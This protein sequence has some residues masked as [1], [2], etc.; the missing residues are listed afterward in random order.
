LLVEC[1]VDAGKKNDA[2]DFS[3]VTSDF[4]EQHTP[5]LYPRIFSIQVH[6]DLIDVSN[7]LTKASPKLLAIYKLQ[8]LKNTAVNEG[9]KESDELREIFLLLTHSSQTQSSA[10]NSFSPDTNH[11]H[12]VI[13]TFYGRIELLLEL[14]FLSLQ[15]KAQFMAEECV[16]ELKTIDDIAVWQRIMVECVE[17]K[18]ALSKQNGNIE[19][20]TKSSVEAQLSVVSRLE[21]LL[22]RA[23]REGDAEV[24]QS[25][26][27]A[28]WNSCL[29]L[30]QHNLR[31]NLKSPL[32]TLSQALENMNSML[33][34]MRCQIHAELAAIEEEAERLEPAA[35]HLQ[36]ALVLD[37]SGQFQQR[38]SFHLHLIQLRSNLY[39][40][41]TSPEDQAAMLIQQTKERLGNETAKKWRHTLVSAG[42]ALAPETFQMVLDA[43][44]TAKVSGSRLQDNVEQLAAKAKHYRTCAQKVE[45]HLARMERDTNYR[46]RYRMRLWVSLVKAARKEELWDICRAACRFCLLYDD[47]RWTVKCKQTYKEECGEREL[48]RLLAE[49]HFINAE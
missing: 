27:V 12:T 25:V 46:E 20:Y 9:R 43:D 45:C 39:R 35:Q 38:L 3:K 21:A 7:I 42:I 41:P 17:C 33:L 40:T 10:S 13:S 32:L 6:H 36:A 28:L 23:L 18:L 5:E 11:S 16:K 14:A 19:D 26:C 1:L 29:P 31:K 48:L 47:G 30:L 49:V 2:A 22:L 15:L 4:I 44:S 37:E 8:K 34:D 24:T